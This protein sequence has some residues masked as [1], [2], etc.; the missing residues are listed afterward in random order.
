[1][2]DITDSNGV[3]VITFNRP[4]ARN[5][6]NFAMY[7]EVSEAIG[8]A[9]ATDDVRALVLT[10]RGS[11]F[12]AGQDLGEMARI[13]AGEPNDG[14]AGGFPALIDALL[15]CPKPVLAPGNGGGV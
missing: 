13:A 10:G 3:R 9:G 14:I 2:I 1:M 12:S 7:S 6:F 4:E 8:A 11:A 5:A 15:G